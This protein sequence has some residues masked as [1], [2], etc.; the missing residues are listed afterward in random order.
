VKNA[1]LS[2]RFLKAI[3]RALGNLD[4]EGLAAAQA[5]QD[6]LTAQRIIQDALLTSMA[7]DR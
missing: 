5:N 7:A 2:I 3:H 4:E 1:K 6:A